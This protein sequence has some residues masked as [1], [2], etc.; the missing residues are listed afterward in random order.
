MDYP[1]GM[2]QGLNGESIM[3]YQGVYLLQRMAE[4]MERYEVPE[5]L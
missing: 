2:V 4:M 5:E 1:A 3:K